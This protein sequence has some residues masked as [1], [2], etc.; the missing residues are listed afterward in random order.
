[1]LFYVNEKIHE[2]LN[3]LW[4]A[5]LFHQIYLFCFTSS[6]S[7][8]E[9]ILATYVVLK[10]QPPAC[11]LIPVPSTVFYCLLFSPLSCRFTRP[12]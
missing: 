3:P 5:L 4:Q 12:R 7:L 10:D 6:Y 9:V 2:H 8:L 1:M 11:V